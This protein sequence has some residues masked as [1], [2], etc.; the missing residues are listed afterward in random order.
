V[1]HT[2][3]GLN[4]VDPTYDPSINAEAEEE[5]VVLN[6]NRPMVNSLKDIALSAKRPT[7]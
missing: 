4:H 6:Q 3:M 1:R 7:F 2:T 5:S